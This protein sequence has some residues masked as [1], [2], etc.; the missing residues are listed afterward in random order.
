MMS[1]TGRR[2]GS[3]RCLRFDTA[4]V[5]LLQRSLHKEITLVDNGHV[6]HTHIFPW[7]NSTPWR[8]ISFW[9]P[10]VLSSILSW[11]FIPFWSAYI[12]DLLRFW[13][14]CFFHSP[15]GSW[16]LASCARG[17]HTNQSI[18]LLAHNLL[19]IHGCYLLLKKIVRRVWCPYNLIRA[20]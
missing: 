5:S 7:S 19:S 4:K 17:T 20:T 14:F 8:S 10:S 12:L 6:S 16:S 11:P 13:P 1:P 15:F 2:I 3:R 9:S 18:L